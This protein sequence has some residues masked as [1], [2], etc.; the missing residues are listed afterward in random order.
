MKSDVAVKTDETEDVEII[1]RVLRGATNDFEI[2]LH[3]YRG[4][5]FKIVAGIIPADAVADL[6]H[7]IFIDVY[8]SLPR[9]DDRK[10]F[11][12]W[13]ASIA[14]RRCYDYWRK[15]YHNREIPLSDLSEEHENWVENVAA[16]QAKDLFEKGE[17]QKEAREVLQWAMT[18]LSAK[19]RMV[20]TLVHL[21]GHSVKEAAQIL[22]WS[23]INVKVRA[24]RSRE[25]LRK[26]IATMLEGESSR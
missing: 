4:Y 11:K 20:L 15:H 2:L 16:T 6:S 12:K 17:K 24:H 25:K 1:D 19:D 23:A 22:G 18:G 9:Y 7:E 26:R 5:V 8:R 13:L 3:R 14:I 10:T 21:E